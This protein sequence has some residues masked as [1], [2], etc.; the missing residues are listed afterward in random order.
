M[1]RLGQCLYICALSVPLSF[2]IFASNELQR[3]V[4][5][6]AASA[7]VDHWALI[8]SHTISL[9]WAERLLEIDPNHHV[10][11]ENRQTM[12]QPTDRLTAIYLL[13]TTES[14]ICLMG[15][16]PDR[17]IEKQ[18]NSYPILLLLFHCF[19]LLFH[20]LLRGSSS[21]S[22]SGRSRSR[23]FSFLRLSIHLG[24]EGLWFRP[25]SLSRISTGLVGRYTYILLETSGEGGQNILQKTLI[26]VCREFRRTGGHYGI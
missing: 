22:G 24:E 19:L 8:H 23:W 9:V 7:A 15:P 25:V 16:H 6:V 2:F 11:R 13:T 3:S 10:S 12:L 1:L 26:F 18:Q 5:G 21:S 4:W 14:N 17:D 20:L